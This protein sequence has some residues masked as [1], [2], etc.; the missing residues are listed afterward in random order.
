VYHLCNLSTNFDIESTTDE[1]PTTQIAIATT[2]TR[3][4]PHLS[5]DFCSPQPTPVSLSPFHPE[6]ATVHARS[7]QYLK[8]EN[9]TPATNDEIPSH[10]ISHQPSFDF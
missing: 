6:F 4:L 5:N 1:L 9:S 8:P 10:N 3:P 7:L 2:T